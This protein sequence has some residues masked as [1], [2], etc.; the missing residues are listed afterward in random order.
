[1]LHIVIS[2]PALPTLIESIMIDNYGL[3]QI[4]GLY[5]PPAS[6]S[7]RNLSAPLFTILQRLEGEL[8]DPLKL[9]AIFVSMLRY[10]PT[11]ADLFLN[12]QR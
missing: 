9:H 1:M 2:W 11:S 7:F 8:S 10:R 4:L 3:R 6:I 5:A 12:C